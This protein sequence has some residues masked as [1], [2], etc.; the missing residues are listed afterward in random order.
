MEKPVDDPSRELI[1]KS[2]RTELLKKVGLDTLRKQVNAAVAT[3]AN[4]ESVSVAQLNT[5]MKE[6]QSD[7]NRLRSLK[8]LPDGAS[9][10]RTQF[11]LVQFLFSAL[12]VISALTAAVTS[13]YM[14]RSHLSEVVEIERFLRGAGSEIRQR[15]NPFMKE[16]KA[17]ADFSKLYEILKEKADRTTPE[18]TADTKP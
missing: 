2:E 3:R 8:A 10:V 16:P 5:R 17:L 9:N 6:L 7:I 13:A 4:G 18:G 14:A 15:P 11:S 1:T 12:F